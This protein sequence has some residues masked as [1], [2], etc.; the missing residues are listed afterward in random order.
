MIVIYAEHVKGLE[1]FE[2]I[3]MII[4]DEFLKNLN[5]ELNDPYIKAANNTQVIWQEFYLFI[6]RKFSQKNRRICKLICKSDC[7]V[8]FKYI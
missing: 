3:P 8:N 6:Q 4:D 5:E 2:E 7:R 1:P